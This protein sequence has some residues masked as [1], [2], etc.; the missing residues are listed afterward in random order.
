MTMYV[1]FI[2]FIVVILYSYPRVTPMRGDLRVMHAYERPFVLTVH[3]YRP[4]LFYIP[5]DVSE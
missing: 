4:L 2:R 3:L 5:S 1:F